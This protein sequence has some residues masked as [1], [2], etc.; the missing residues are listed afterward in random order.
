M[1]LESDKKV[2]NLFIA[3]KARQILHET[4]QRALA[5]CECAQH[6]GFLIKLF[7][8][9][10]VL[11][12]LRF[13]KGA[14]GR[15]PRGLHGYDRGRLQPRHG[16][17]DVNVCGYAHGCVSGRRGNGDGCGRAC[18]YGCAARIWCPF[19]AAPSQSP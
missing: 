4:S 13:F 9:E 19:P 2:K 15:A 1:I 8:Q 11:Q 18:A 12:I 6:T 14:Y 17:E 10:S 16:H 5:R 3:P 7:N